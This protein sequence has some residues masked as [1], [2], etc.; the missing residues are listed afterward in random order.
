[1]PKLPQKLEKRLVTRKEQDSLRKLGRENELVDFS[2]NDYLGFSTNRAIFEQAYKIL[3]DHKLLVNGS[4]G[5]RLL[6]GNHSL[7]EIAEEK[8]AAF[9]NSEAALI[10]NSGYDANLGLF[11]SLPQ[12]GDV[13]LYDEFAHASIRDGINLSRATAYKFHH[14]NLKDLEQKLKRYKK[15]FSGE[16]FI[17]TETVFSMDG[18]APNLEALAEIATTYNSFLVLDEAHSTGVTGKNGEGPVKELGL[19][20]KIFARIITFGKALGTHGAVILGNNAL[21]DYL[22]NFARS[23]IYTTA[24]PP[25]SVAGIIAAYQHLEKEAALEAI[26]LLQEKIELFLMEVKNHALEQLFI[27]SK[28]AIHCCVIPGNST[29]KEISKRLAE[30]GF[31]V[32]AILSPTVPKGEERLRFCLH[33]YNSSEELKTVLSLLSEEILMLKKA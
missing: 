1:M 7:Y 18:D 15:K 24:L 16:L 4:G 9:H 19:E 30:K 11:G 12:R 5:S 6:T 10:F 26:P 28:S 27:P 3:E 32:K 21:K 22:I 25:H 20:D 29:V 33:S 17:V 23:F 8:L 2:S 13:I 14:N 31:D